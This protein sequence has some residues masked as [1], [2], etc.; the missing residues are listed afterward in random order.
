M[1]PNPVFGYRAHNK[2]FNKCQENQLADYIK[3]SA[4]LYFGLSPTAIR[5]LAFSFSLKINLK[6]PKKTG[7]IKSK[8]ELIGFQPSLK[9]IQHCPFASQKLQASQEL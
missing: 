4:D 5:K 8:Q 7:L 3:N 6:V 2:V 9:E 1:G